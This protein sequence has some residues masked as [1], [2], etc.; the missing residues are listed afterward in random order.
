L[1]SSYDTVI[2]GAGISGLACARK[3]MREGVKVLV[4]EARA[5]AGGRA[6]TLTHLSS[7]VELGAEFMHSAD[8][9]FLKAF[10]DAGI[11]FMDLKDDHF[12]LEGGKLVKKKGFWDEIQKISGLF[13]KDLKTDRSAADFLAANGA[14]I[15]AKSRALFVQYI[16]GF[17]AADPAK[18]SERALARAEQGDGPELNKVEQFRPLPGYSALVEKW[19]EECGDSS[20]W[21]QLEALVQKIEWSEGEVRVLGRPFGEVEAKTAVIT[22]PLGVLKSANSLSQIKFDPQP[23]G[24]N[25]ALSGLEVG[26][27]E[28][29]TFEFGERFW[30]NL[31][32]EPVAFM[33]GPVGDYFSVW[34][35]G[36]PVRTPFL[37]AWQGGNKAREVASWPRE[38]QIAAA[39]KTLSKISGKSTAALRKLMRSAHFHNWDSDPYAMGAYTYVGVGGLEKA[40]RLAK[41]FGGTLVFAGEATAEGDAMATVH[42]AMQ[43]GERAAR[44]ILSLL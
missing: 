35:T 20:D 44:Q 2:V 10:H 42:G 22:V 17:H 30:E 21:L 6:H 26:H 8:K 43:S 5:R 28:R 1:K 23:P 32:D 18:I 27:V 13:K 41:P 37:V 29:I 14:R 11:P 25:D 39:L 36:S 4:L 3:L 12:H 19:I 40:K 9:D 34:W 7:P 38:K 33:H 15:K 16:E 31:H 24:L